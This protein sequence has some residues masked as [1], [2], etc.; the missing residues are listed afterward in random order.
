L[1]ITKNSVIFEETKGAMMP[2][3]YTESDIADMRETF[4]RV[5]NPENWKLP[6]DAWI[7][8]S[9]FKMVAEAV[10]FFTGSELR[11]QG[12]PQPLT[13]RIL[14]HADGYYAACGA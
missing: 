7:P 8:G 1:T 13:G 4:D 3:T 10:E 9:A 6:I 14:V 12:G 5:A 2:K 11:V